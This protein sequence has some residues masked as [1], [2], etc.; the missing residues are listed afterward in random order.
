MDVLVPDFSPESRV[1]G[2]FADGE[3]MASVA[4][5]PAQSAPVEK[6]DPQK[7][8]ADP[9]VLPS[10]LARLV[11]VGI[12]ASLLWKVGYLVRGYLTNLQY[13]LQDDFFPKSM[14]SSISVALFYLM[15]VGAAVWLLLK[16][17]RRHGWLFNSV[18]TASLFGLCI[19]QQ[20]YNDM[21]FLTAF[22]ASVWLGWFCSRIG[23]DPASR[24]LPKAAFLAQLI[25]SAIFLGGAVGKMTPG[26]WS[27]QVM[28]ELY[29]ANRDYWFFHM[30]RRLTGP[31]G[32]GTFATVYSRM[33]IVV[34][35]SCGLLWLLPP[36]VAATLAII[37][38]VGIALFSNP[39]L[40]SVLSALLGLGA[41]GFWTADDE[42][43]HVT[44][45]PALR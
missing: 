24:L 6:G 36:R 45:S 14:Q 35:A 18:L 40:F 37:V 5:P 32:L 9:L 31:E 12:L 20:S 11:T 8:G 38:L 16:P 44:A 25:L 1:A 27:G 7:A 19:H 13:P 17:I 39:Y 3:G 4:R 29:F 30:I 42:T 10:N 22:W 21:T 34:E 26:Y 33:V 15:A 41:V 28:Y 2:S 43:P 23:V